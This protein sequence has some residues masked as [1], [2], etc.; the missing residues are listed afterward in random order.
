MQRRFERVDNC[1]WYEMVIWRKYNRLG[2]EESFMSQIYE[3]GFNIDPGSIYIDSF[4]ER[5]PAKDNQKTIYTLCRQFEYSPIRCFLAKNIT[6][7]FKKPEPPIGKF[8]VK[9]MREAKSKGGIIGYFDI[10]RNPEKEAFVAFEGY[11]RYI[12]GD[13]KKIKD[14][15]ENLEKKFDRRKKW[16]NRCKYLI[17]PL[18]LGAAG[19]YI[20]KENDM[21]W[22]WKGPAIYYGALLSSFI[23]STSI[24]DHK[25]NKRRKAFN[26]WY[27]YGP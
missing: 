26:H 25:Y 1:R 9:R 16:R 4:E 15:Q 11:Q 21:S 6:R 22:L 17:A 27:S 2:T 13:F 12:L 18:L 5:F 19:V 24:E 7:I 14:K 23:I 10:F 20:S 3:K 8:F